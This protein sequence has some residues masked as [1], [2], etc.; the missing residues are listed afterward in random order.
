MAP[1]I[2][3]G[4]ITS[5][6][7]VNGD[8]KPRI[9]EIN[10]LRTVAEPK[11][12]APIACSQFTANCLSEYNDSQDKFHKMCLAKLNEAHKRV[13][14]VTKDSHGTLKYKRMTHAKYARK[15]RRNER[16]DKER[17]AFLN[18]D[19]YVI[20]SLKI[21]FGDREAGVDCAPKGRIHTTP[22]TKRKKALKKVL[23]LKRMSVMDLAN[24]ICKP[25]IDSGKPI[26]IIGRRNKHIAHCRTVWKG[27]R[28]V[29]KVKTHH[30]ESVMRNVDVNLTHDTNK[31]IE[32]LAEAAYTGRA[33]RDSEIVRGFSGF[34][35]PKSRIPD[36]KTAD[37]YKFLVVRGRWRKTLVDARV[38]IS[39]EILEG[40]NHY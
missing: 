32:V 3:F 12:L 10:E 19:P 22:S 8:S 30:E 14:S 4:T 5:D 38:H 28:R 9:T 17:Q 35:I 13:A 39:P 23:K 25:F 36:L 7:L 33:L 21:A 2:Q 6:V 29:L 20:T 26:E 37:N 31:L 24:S 1:N 11:P 34:V 18:A 16:L 27:D 15:V 40:I